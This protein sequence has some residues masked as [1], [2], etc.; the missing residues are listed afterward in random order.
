MG[1]LRRSVLF[2]IQIGHLILDSRSLLQH[3]ELSFQHL[4]IAIRVN[5]TV[6]LL[7]HWDLSYRH[8]SII[9]SFKAIS[10]LHCMLS[11]QRHTL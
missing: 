9:A 10:T 2:I 3:W 6:S 8:R 1:A 7:H 4:T 5:N 11:F